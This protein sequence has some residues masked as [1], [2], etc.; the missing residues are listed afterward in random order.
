MYLKYLRIL[1]KNWDFLSLTSTSTVWWIFSEIFYV[2]VSICVHFNLQVGLQ[3]SVAYNKYF[4]LHNALWGLVIICSHMANITELHSA[5]KSHSGAY[6][7]M[8]FSH[9]AAG[10]SSGMGREPNCEDTCK[11][12]TWMAVYLMSIHILFAKANSMATP[13]FLG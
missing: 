13:K 5:H 4:L 1:H 3:T 10:R 7:S 11:V 12:S 9:M 8:L 2:F 6:S